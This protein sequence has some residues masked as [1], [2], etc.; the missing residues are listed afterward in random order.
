MSRVL[1]R[2][3]GGGT[4]GAFVDG[5]QF[6]L[7]PHIKPLKDDLD[8][9]LLGAIARNKYAGGMQA[10]AIDASANGT[11]DLSPWFPIEIDNQGSQLSGFT[12]ANSATLV[13]QFRFMV[14]VSNAGITV[15]PRVYDITAAAAATTSGAA[16]CSAT[17]DD[18]SGTNQQQ[19]LALTLPNAKHK[20]KPQI[21][22]AGTPAAGYQ[23]WGV[24][25]F[26]CYVENS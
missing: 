7:T 25:V 1:K 26:D 16:A 9:L 19:T 3:A 4:A 5:D 21:T 10:F 13:V 17:N 6:K 15:T 12:D 18:Y 14:R 20:F 24:A 11:F 8:L 2:L 22:I 23:A